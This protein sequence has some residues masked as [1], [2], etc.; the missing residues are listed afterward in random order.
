MTQR[1]TAI[2][3]ATSDEISSEVW[4]VIE[5]AMHDKLYENGVADEDFEN[6]KKEVASQ[7]I[8]NLE[9]IL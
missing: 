8:E 9:E 5:A 7:L 1:M 6:F 4:E 3:G 2:T